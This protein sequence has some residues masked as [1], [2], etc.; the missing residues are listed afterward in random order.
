MNSYHLLNLKL[1]VSKTFLATYLT[2]C[3][4]CCRQ[5]SQ[6][7][8]H[9]LFYSTFLVLCSFIKGMMHRLSHFTMGRTLFLS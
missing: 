4:A 5:V 1:Y 9:L 2:S 7:T 6:E 8:A 3:L